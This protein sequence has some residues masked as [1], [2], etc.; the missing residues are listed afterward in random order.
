MDHSNIGRLQVFGL[1]PVQHVG[2]DGRACR[3][4]QGFGERKEG[5]GAGGR[6][7][8]CHQL[9][10]ISQPTSLCPL[11]FA[12]QTPSNVYLA[13]DCYNGGSLHY[14]IYRPCKPTMAN[15][16][17]VKKGGLGFNDATVGFY[18]GEILMALAYIHKKGILHRD[19]KVQI[20]S[21]ASTLL[22]TVP[23]VHTPC[24]IGC[25]PKRS[26]P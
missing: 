25:A 8:G 21:R 5:R 20:R 11:Q 14:H 18:A 2:V 1:L 3:L 16:G 6:V 4:T 9:H 17:Q 10:T 26:R 7:E 24:I 23:Y 22:S 15:S 19:L 12:F 13:F